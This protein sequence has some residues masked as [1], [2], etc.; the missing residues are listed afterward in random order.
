M[1]RLVA[2]A[3]SLRCRLKFSAKWSGIPFYV[4]GEKSASSLQDISS[5]FGSVDVRGQDSGNA[6]N[7]ANYILADL[8]DEPHSRLLY[9][10]GDK[11]RDT[12]TQILANSNIKLEPLQ[13]YQTQLSPTF[14]R[15]LSL[16]IESSSHQ[17]RCRF[18]HSTF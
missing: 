9:L 12:M 6:A 14:H 5:E 1:G 7:L 8:R 18:V 13:V 15:R 11:N 4:V 16:A 3:V 2:C 17:G 10:T